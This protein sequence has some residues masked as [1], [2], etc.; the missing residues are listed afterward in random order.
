MNKVKPLVLPV[1]LLITYPH[2]CNQLSQSL[3]ISNS[4]PGLQLED[5]LLTPFLLGHKSELGLKIVWLSC[6]D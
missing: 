5:I 3:S 4:S 1:V 6:I 2:S